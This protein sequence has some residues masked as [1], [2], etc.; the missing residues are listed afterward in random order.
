MYCMHYN[1]FYYASMQYFE[2]HNTKWDQIRNVFMLNPL[3]DL[4]VYQLV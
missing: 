4:E 3:F 2:A 1:A